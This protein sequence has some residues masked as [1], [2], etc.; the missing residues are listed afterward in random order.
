MPPVINRWLDISNLKAFDWYSPYRDRIDNWKELTGSFDV[1]L[2]VEVV[3]GS[4]VEHEEAE[5]DVCPYLRQ[6]RGSDIC[7]GGDMEAVPIVILGWWS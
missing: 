7:C 2:D 5:G 6:W 3:N 4:G 1:H